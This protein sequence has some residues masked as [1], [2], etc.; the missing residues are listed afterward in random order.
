MKKIIYILTVAAIAAGCSGNKTNSAQDSTA[1]TVAASTDT[2]QVPANPEAAIMEFENVKYDFGKVKE[3]DNVSY[4]FKFKNSGKSPLIITN[5][6]AT[7]GC[8]TPT[9][10]HEPIAPGGSG[11]IDV[12]F[13]STG[14]NGLQDKVITVTSNA[15]PSINEVHLTGEVVAKS[16]N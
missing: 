15:S 5:A 3:G 2:S 13:N 7:C 4:T 11:N 1:A 8:T 6:T 10:P 9:Y 14:K 12:T 16:A